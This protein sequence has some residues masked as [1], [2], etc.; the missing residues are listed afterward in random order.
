M[1]VLPLSV[2][3]VVLPNM[4]VDRSG[5]LAAG[6]CAAF[7]ADAPTIEDALADAAFRLVGALAA[8]CIADE[9]AT[10]DPLADPM[11]DS[12]AIGRE[13]AT[14]ACTACE[15]VVLSIVGSEVSADVPWVSSPV[16]LSCC[17]SCGAVKDFFA[18]GREVALGAAAR[19]G[20]DPTDGASVRDGF[21]MRLC[22]DGLAALAFGRV[23]SAMAMGAVRWMRPS[24]ITAML[25]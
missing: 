12:S 5:E 3:L 6:V 17:R 24:G 7:A 10:L 13:V 21:R 20:V 25:I 19:C 8:P 9:G 23:S 1:V 15:L 18:D 16:E 2:G 22:V 4:L 11:R 14:G